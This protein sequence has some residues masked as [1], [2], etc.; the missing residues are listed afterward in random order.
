[1]ILKLFRVLLDSV[2]NLIDVT[3]SLFSTVIYAIRVSYVDASL[4]LL[5]FSQSSINIVP[6]RIGVC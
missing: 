1:M 3:I 2:T 6:T 4:L 5:R